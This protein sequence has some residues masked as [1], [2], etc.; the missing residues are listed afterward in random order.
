M[1]AQSLLRKSTGLNL[2]RA[3]AERAVQ[4]RMAATGVSDRAAYLRD[5]TPEEMTALTE[6]VVVPESWLFRDPQAFVLAT[7]FA[8]ERLA[9]GARLVRALCIPCASGEEPYS[10]A[11]AFCDAGIPL[12]AF[13]ID[14]VDLSPACIERAETG[15][16]GRNAF[17][18]QDLEF[19]DRYFE[20]LGEDC[21]RV[22]DIVR[23]RVRFRQGNLLSGDIAPARHYDIIFCRNLLIYFDKPTTAQA[24]GRL[25]F[26]LADDGIL[27]AGY[28]EVPSI[29]Q[30][31]FAALPYRQAF[32][33]RKELSPQPPAVAPAVP[34]PARRPAARRP[35]TAAASV[36]AAA[37][38]AVPAAS[39]RVR[40]PV[41]VQ[42]PPAAPATDGLLASAR[43]LA[44]QGRMKDADAACRAVIAQAPDTAEAYFI[45][46]LL[47]EAASEPEQAQAQL[48]RCLYL[49]PDHYEAL[50][51][52]A[53]LAERQ[54]DH[55][56]A[57]T[58]KARAARVYQ[59]QTRHLPIN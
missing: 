5:I 44:D 34:Q 14:A 56:M 20:A 59:R 42:P 1:T 13:A 32:A 24:I 48:K 53:L 17:R 49:Q 22:N 23:R 27:L 8:Q 52:L 46:G 4:Q 15:I 38:P 50:C 58:L 19:R 29:T 28:A 31:G 41:A 18:S 39:P 26:M 54:G 7:E 36:R 37:S 6:L 9:S 33:L 21:Y 16:Y 3:T 51:H 30:Q 12:P 43:T 2:S 40:P 10:L 11:M 47:N 25:S 57:A 45:L 35:A 55:G